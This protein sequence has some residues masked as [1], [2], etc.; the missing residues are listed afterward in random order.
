[1]INMNSKK[2]FTLVELLAVIV[3]LGIVVSIG[4]YTIT[5]AIRKTREN[6]YQVTIN[7]IENT[8]NDYLLENSGKLFFISNNDGTEYQCITIQQLIDAGYF[9]NDITNS[10]ISKDTNV[11]IDDYVIVNRNVSTK[12]VNNINFVNNGNDYKKCGIAINTNSDIVF[13][14]TPSE[15]SNNNKTVTIEYK[16][17][18][19]RFNDYRYYYKYGDNHETEVDS[20]KTTI[21]IDSN[22]S[23]QALI[24]S[25]DGTVIKNKTINENQI[26]IDITNPN[27][28][29][30]VEAGQYSTEKD[31]TITASDSQSGIDYMNVKVYKDDTLVTDK[32]NYK[33]NSYI[34]EMN[35][36]GNWKIETEVFDK[37]G[38]KNTKT[39]EYIIS[40]KFS[41]NDFKY[42]GNYEFINEDDDN[43]YIKFLSSGVLTV[44][45]NFQ[46]EAFLVGGGGAGG[47]GVKGTMGTYNGNTWS[48]IGAGGGGGGGGY[49][50]TEII[51]LNSSISYTVVVGAGGAHPGNT[52]A[53]PK[54]GETTL[55]KNGDTIIAS[56]AGGLP[57]D[58]GSSDGPGNGGA[59]GSTGG[60]G[61]KIDRYGTSSYTTSTAGADGEYAFGSSLYGGKY[62][63]GG[64]GGSSV[65]GNDINAYYG[66]RDS[67]VNAPG[68]SKGGGTGGDPW[69]AGSDATYY[70]AGGGGGGSG[71]S[72]ARGGAGFKG[73]VIIRNVR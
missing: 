65:S 43:W 66:T 26:K 59:G 10:L 54:P 62:G 17:R 31:V 33:E 30:S 56:A 29:Y 61:S 8:A 12:V 23:I 39:A 48:T 21:D 19:N 51:S 1:M 71:G 52:A 24:K 46:I 41:E 57:G 63:A 53:N 36:G 7:E 2:G 60:K 3:V 38:N 6:G 37:A 25:S 5:N 34:V 69:K 35:S 28:N 55:I 11:N 58:R 73:I 27:V 68:G 14:I 40:T 64:G 50:T 18:D 15:W 20:I 22:V 9:K 16:L 42:T 44:S 49:R 45:S 67:G 72:Y 47:T 4:I 70:G 32:S 13:T